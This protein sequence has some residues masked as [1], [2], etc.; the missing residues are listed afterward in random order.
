V[1]VAWQ[2]PA[3]RIAVAWFVA[4][5]ILPAA[6]SAGVG[7]G[8]PALGNPGG[9]PGAKDVQLMTVAAGVDRSVAQITSAFY[10]SIGTTAAAFY[11]ERVASVASLDKN[12]DGLLCVAEAWGEDLNPN[13]HWVKVYAGLLANPSEPLQFLFTDNRTGRLKG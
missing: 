8:C 11:A 5:L 1:A 2:R 4:A 6:V 7:V 3:A 13:S 10:A 12:S 9:N